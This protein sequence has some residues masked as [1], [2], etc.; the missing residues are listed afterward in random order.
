[1]SPWIYSIIDHLALRGGGGGQDDLVGRSFVYT[2]SPGHV[3]A[4][5][6]CVHKLVYVL[7]QGCAS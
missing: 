7:E 5:S 6:T 2:C 4:S 3:F 1:M